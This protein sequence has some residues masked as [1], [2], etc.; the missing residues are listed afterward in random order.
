MSMKRT[1]VILASILLVVML[2]L[3]SGC[4]VGGATI[5]LKGMSLGTIAMDGK[6]IE[7]LPSDKVDLLLQVAANEITVTHTAD[8]SVLTL[9][10]SGGTIEIK[11]GSIFL[12]GIKP[13]QV[14]VEW[15][16]SPKD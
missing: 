2:A 10:P 3:S 7:G 14:K 8:G 13:E 6:P 16:I 5:K 11:S 15:A 4:N 9:S 12:K 1:I